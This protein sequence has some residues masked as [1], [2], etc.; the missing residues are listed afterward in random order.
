MKHKHSL[1]VI[2]GVA[3][4]IGMLSM[5]IGC[6]KSITDHKYSKIKI[7]QLSKLLDKSFLGEID[8]QTIEDSIYAGYVSGLEDPMT[9]Y[10]NKE[11]LKAQQV[12]EQ[13]KYIGT[14]IAF[15]W[16]LDGRYIIITDVVPNSPAAREGIKQGDRITEIDGIK[17]I[18][19]NETELL[20]KLTYTG[21]KEVSY[22]IEQNSGEQE[23]K[24]SLKSEVIAVKGIEYRL[25]NEDVGYI[26]I[27]SIK[28]NMTEELKQDIEILRKKGAKHF[29]I[30]IRSAYSNNIE[31]IYNTCNLF[32]GRQTVFKVK[33]KLGE[34]TS[35]ETKE[36]VYDEPLVVLINGR[37][38][39]ALEAFASAVSYLKRGVVIGEAS[40]G[41][42]LVSEIIPL[43]DET[44]LMV[45]TGVIYTPNDVSLKDSKVI[46]DV[47]IKNNAAGIIELVTTGKVSDKNDLQLME[48]LSHF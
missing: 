32:M 18:L 23:R 37:T 26:S 42:G 17:V 6:S 22:S 25:I 2:T 13:G 29:I 30:D 40:A 31:E 45:S 21:D 8:K 47:E 3:L 43:N 1:G 39:G 12:L 48:A 41:M 34:I 38:R 46:P 7:N 19:S 5:T 24:V 36:A 14:G 33:N 16:G 10:L 9:R 15:E 44:G 27:F 11:A 35:Y 4:G 28:E 20:K